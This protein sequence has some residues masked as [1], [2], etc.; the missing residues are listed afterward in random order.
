M[1]S[2]TRIDRISFADDFV[3]GSLT[4]LQHRYQSGE[5]PVDYVV[6]QAIAMRSAD[7]LEVFKWL[8]ST[9]FRAP[10]ESFWLFVA[11]STMSVEF[12]KAAL[13]VRP[14]LQVDPIEYQ[15]LRCAD[16]SLLGFFVSRTGWK[17]EYLEQID[18]LLNRAEFDIERVK[19][20]DMRA[21]FL[22]KSGYTENSYNRWRSGLPYEK[23]M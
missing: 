4:D 15:A 3:S 22:E 8:L 9:D 19:W 5:R 7:R 11:G 12:A 23:L 17:L 20:S 14:H 2:R 18:R 13:Q 10:P 16:K 21:W 6:Y 1:S